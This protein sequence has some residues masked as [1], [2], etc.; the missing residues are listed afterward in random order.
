MRLRD[1]DGAVQ[2]VQR[3]IEL[4]PHDAT[5]YVTLAMLYAGPMED[6]ERAMALIERGGEVNADD[7]WYFYIVGN[8]LW[9]IDATEPALRMLENAAAIEPGNPEF[10][11]RLADIYYDLDRGEDALPRYQRY[12]TIVGDAAEDWVRERVAELE[13]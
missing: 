6:Q 13:N 12:L 11:R 4:E 9:E 3:A 7:P 1:F 8:A 5:F 10:L 2:D